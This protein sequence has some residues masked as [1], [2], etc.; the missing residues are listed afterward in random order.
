MIKIKEDTDRYSHRKS[1]GYSDDEIEYLNILELNAEETE[2]LCKQERDG[3]L[4]PKDEERLEQIWKLQ[5]L[6]YGE[7]YD[8]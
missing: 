5:E 6:Y 4:L 3:Y 2:L 1:L 8:D 7:E